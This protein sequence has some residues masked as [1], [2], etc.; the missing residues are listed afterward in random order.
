MWVVS[1]AIQPQTDGR[2]EKPRTTIKSCSSLT[3]LD[4]MQCCG[5]VHSRPDPSVL[6]PRVWVEL[7][8][9]SLRR[10][11]CGLTKNPEGGN[12]FLDDCAAQQHLISVT[13]RPEL[14]QGFSNDYEGFAYTRD[15]STTARALSSFAN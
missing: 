12:V 13:D 5:N 14:A 15:A 1:A 3:G 11:A 8:A 9:Q 2:G 7:A 6:M 10:G 4:D